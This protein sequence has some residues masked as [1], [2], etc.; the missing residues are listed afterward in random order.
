MICD[1]KAGPQT[2][3]DQDENKKKK[4]LEEQMKKLMDQMSITDPE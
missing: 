4:M 3:E 1:F 2:Q